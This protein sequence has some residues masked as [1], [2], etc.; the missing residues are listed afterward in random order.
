MRSR[1][2]KTKEAVLAFLMRNVDL[3]R[4]TIKIFE[5]TVHRTTHIEV[6]KQGPDVRWPELMVEW[7]PIWRG[8]ITLPLQLLKTYPGE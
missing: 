5:D 4:Y 3:K 8:S 7:Y 2:L 6:W 1:P